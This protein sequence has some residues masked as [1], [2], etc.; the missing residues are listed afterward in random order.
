MTQSKTPL[1]DFETLCEVTHCLKTIAHPH[2]LHMIQMLLRERYTVGEL[3]A[4][5]GIPSHVASMHLGVMRDRGL[6]T[7]QREG[8]KCYYEIAEPRLASLIEFVES[9][10]G[11]KKKK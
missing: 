1:F 3:A 7:A 9:R 8:R 11:K 6:L 2:R 4:T 5:C 10:F